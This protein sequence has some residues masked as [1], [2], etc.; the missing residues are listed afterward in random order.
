MKSL[1]FVSVLFLITSVQ[2]VES[3][4]IKTVRK[5]ISSL[6]NKIGRK[7]KSGSRL[8]IQD[9]TL[10]SERLSSAQHEDIKALIA[11]TL[12]GKSFRTLVAPTTLDK[13]LKDLTPTAAAEIAGKSSFVFLYQL[14]FVSSRDIYGCNPLTDCHVWWKWYRFAVRA[15]PAVFR[16]SALAGKPWRTVRPA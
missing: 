3:K 1:L 9:L 5:S 4:N 10:K 6:S 11:Y 7:P 2:A 15:G 13:A 12:L 8:L 14:C 16:H